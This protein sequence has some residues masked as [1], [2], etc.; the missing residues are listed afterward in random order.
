MEFFMQ[1]IVSHEEAFHKSNDKKPFER[2][3]KKG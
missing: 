3:S 2:F 1:K